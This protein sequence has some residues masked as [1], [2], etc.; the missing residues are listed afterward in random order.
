MSGFLTHVAPQTQT[1]LQRLHFI[2]TTLLE[3]ARD[4]Y[5]KQHLVTIWRH[6]QRKEY[7]KALY[8]LREEHFDG[9]QEME[10]ILVRLEP[11]QYNYVETKK[12]AK[13]SLK[14]TKECP[15][16]GCSERVGTRAKTCE[17]CG[18]ATTCQNCGHTTQKRRKATVETKA[19]GETKSTGETKETQEEEIPPLSNPRLETG[20]QVYIR[21]KKIYLD[22]LQKQHGQTFGRG[23]SDDR[24]AVQKIWKIL[25]KE[26]ILTDQQNFPSKYRKQWQDKQIK[27]E[28]KKMHPS[29]KM[30]KMNEDDPL[31]QKWRLEEPPEIPL[32]PIFFPEAMSEF[33]VEDSYEALIHLYLE[34]SDSSGEFDMKYRATI[35]KKY[36]EWE[37]IEDDFVE[38]IGE[39]EFKLVI[40]CLHTYGG[41]GHPFSDNE[42]NVNVL[43]DVEKKL[44]TEAKTAKKAYDTQLATHAGEGE[45]K[46]AEL[47]KL[48]DDWVDA[49]NVA[50]VDWETIDWD[51]KSA[52]ERP[53]SGTWDEHD[54]TQY[55]IRAWAERAAYL[56]MPKGQHFKIQFGD[57]WFDGVIIENKPSTNPPSLK[58]KYITLPADADD[59]EPHG[60]WRPQQLH[61]QHD[62]FYLIDE[63]EDVDVDEL[64]NDNN[65]GVIKDDSF[66]TS[67]DED[68]DELIEG[69]IT[70]TYTDNGI[71]YKGIA[72]D[73]KIDSE[74]NAKYFI[75]GE[76]KEAWVKDG[77]FE[78]YIEN[79]STFAVG[80]TVFVEDDA[81]GYV[82]LSIDG[83]MATFGNHAPVELED[84]ESASDRTSHER[85]ETDESENKTIDIYRT[86]TWKT[87]TVK[88]I[89]GV[90]QQKIEPYL[91]YTPTEWYNIQK[92]IMAGLD[93]K[94]T[95]DQPEV[96][97]IQDIATGEVFREI[98]ATEIND[99][100]DIVNVDSEAEVLSESS[101]SESS[102]SEDG[103]SESEDGAGFSD[104]IYSTDE[105]D[106]EDDEFSVGDQVSFRGSVWTVVFRTDEDEDEDE[107]DI[108]IQ[109]GKEIQFINKDDLIKK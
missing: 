66:E 5:T 108:K 46:D 55:I 81:N 63:D 27:E 109:Q 70:L 37:K 91:Q 31:V 25:T 93:K 102:E 41:E 56:Q 29:E 44:N 10:N 80:D 33:L 71:L 84:L 14:G 32:L 90:G 7:S 86:H 20:D 21:L 49:E 79:E 74:G 60:D 8:L 65:E 23:E 47:H 98:Q 64:I 67:D 18:H 101:E 2:L 34:P 83:E 92:K 72:T 78:V 107:D 75:K 50:T 85:I 59:S 69:E 16:G 15:G 73:K 17:D 40:E 12:T 89:K 28:W 58:Y 106:K 77:E 11:Y 13:K 57:E 68:D 52:W 95:P 3:N 19:T 53:N 24:K 99:A 36:I 42:K 61:L 43:K 54:I 62:T 94:D 87:R 1:P 4:E 26:K 6:I 39:I 48:K 97:D 96:V 45:Y 100:T 88:I 76:N 38:D 104:A 51:F 103:E 30:K 82:I 105:D 35:E 22:K 9:R